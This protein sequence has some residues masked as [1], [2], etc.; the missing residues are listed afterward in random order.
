[1]LTFALV[2]YG[3]HRFKYSML[4]PALCMV[5]DDHQAKV[6]QAV[7]DALAAVYSNI[8]N[9]LFNLVSQVDLRPEH[10]DAIKDRC[11]SGSLPSYNDDGVALNP[12]SKSAQYP[13]DVQFQSRPSPLSK[14][15][16]TRHPAMSR[17][18]PFF[19]NRSRDME[20]TDVVRFSATMDMQQTRNSEQMSATTWFK[21][22]N[23]FPTAS[24][25][26]PLTIDV[27]PDSAGSTVSNM[28]P[29]SPNSRR[30]TS[31]G[32]SPMLRQSHRARSPFEEPID[33]GFNSIQSS[34]MHNHQRVDIPKSPN[35]N[36]DQWGNELPHSRHQR[37]LQPPT[38]ILP[39]APHHSH[40]PMSS[41]FL[42][43][44]F[45]GMLLNIFCLGVHL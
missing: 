44:T 22:T 32:K 2:K 10:L 31:P 30:R 24:F 21:S 38:N 23:S 25:P 33:S 12:I 5:L 17:K 28:G 39:P 16:S 13:P 11:S 26:P 15:M 42:R 9:E 29:M 37:S 34:P 8:G 3:T 27:P 43:K 36:V 14:S 19:P 41:H 35:G 18:I 20:A 40:S 7:L 45:D 4:V 1:M 6:Q